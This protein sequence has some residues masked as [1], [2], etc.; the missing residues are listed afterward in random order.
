MSSTP[1]IIKPLFPALIREFAAFLIDN[2]NFYGSFPATTF[3]EIYP[4][5][6]AKAIF[7]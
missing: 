2:S 7:C 1:V 3:P 6:L 4:Y 5:I